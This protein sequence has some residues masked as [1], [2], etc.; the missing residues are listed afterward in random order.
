MDLNFETSERQVDGT[1]VIEVTG[2]VDV[3]TAPDLKRQLQRCVE[4]ART[5]V[6]VDLLG[7]PFLDSTGLGVLVEAAKGLGDQGGSLR[8]VLSEPRVTKVFE[9][10]GLTG[11]LPIYA[12]LEQALAP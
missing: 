8:I 3:A 5:K 4:Q 10:T 6:V 7:V 1:T 11:T 9:I 12:D 2:E